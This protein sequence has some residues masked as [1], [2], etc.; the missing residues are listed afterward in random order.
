MSNDDDDDDDND[1]CERDN[2]F[3]REIYDC[4]KKQSKTLQ[5]FDKW[6]QAEFF[7]FFKAS[8]SVFPNL[9]WFAAPLL[10]IEDI[11]RHR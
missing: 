5:F 7:N 8:T 2:I 3:F 9:F 11:G 6:T 1:V 10:S 4:I